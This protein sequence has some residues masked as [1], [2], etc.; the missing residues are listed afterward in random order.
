MIRTEPLLSAAEETKAWIHKAI[1]FQ[2]GS[3]VNKPMFDFYE[4]LIKKK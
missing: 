3:E 4:L 1:F 2:L